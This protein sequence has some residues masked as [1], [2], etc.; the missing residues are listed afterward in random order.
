MNQ[1]FSRSIINQ[2]LPKIDDVRGREREK[3]RDRDNETKLISQ[4]TFGCIF[5][6]AIECDGSISKNKK[7]ASK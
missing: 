1:I 4:G 5:Y 7:Y 6:P 3:D 2:Q